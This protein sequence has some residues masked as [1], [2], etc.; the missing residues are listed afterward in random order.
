M[1]AIT[2]E[3]D[4]NPAGT[5]AKPPDELN[6]CAVEN[7]N[8]NGTD[9]KAVS[10]KVKLYESLVEEYWSSVVLSESKRTKQAPPRRKRSSL[11]KD[12][13]TKLKKRISSASLDE[14]ELRLDKL[15]QKRS[16]T[17]LPD[18]SEANPPIVVK[19]P[20]KR[21]KDI[22]STPNGAKIKPPRK[23]IS[24]S[25]IHAES[26]QSDENSLKVEANVALTNR[27]ETSTTQSEVKTRRH[28]IIHKSGMCEGVRRPRHASFSEP[29]TS[30]IMN[31]EQ[32]SHPIEPVRASVVILNQPKAAPRKRSVLEKAHSIAAL[33][34]TEHLRRSSLNVRQKLEKNRRKFTF[35][36]KI[37]SAFKSSSDCWPLAR[38]RKRVTR[39]SS[40]PPLKERL[41]ASVSTE[42]FS[43]IFINCDKKMSSGLPEEWTSEPA[44]DAIF[45]T[46]GREN[47][48]FP[49]Y[50]HATPRKQ[51]AVRT[52]RDK[53]LRPKILMSMNS[54][55]SLDS[56]ALRKAQKFLI[57]NL[58]PS[59]TR[60]RFK[61]STN[62]SPRD[63]QTQNS[64]DS[65]KNS[66]DTLDSIT[67]Q[68]EDNT[69]V[70]LTKIERAV[71]HDQANHP[72]PSG[73]KLSLKTKFFLRASSIPDMA[74]RIRK[75]FSKP[76]LATTSEFD[77]TGSESVTQ[78]AEPASLIENVPSPEQM[79]IERKQTQNSADNNTNEKINCSQQPIP[80]IIVHDSNLDQKYQNI[81]LSAGRPTQCNIGIN[82]NEL[83]SVLPSTLTEPT[84]TEAKD[85]SKTEELNET[86][87]AEI[88]PP[89]VSDCS[90]RDNVAKNT[91]SCASQDIVSTSNSCDV[92]TPFHDSSENDKVLGKS[93]SSEITNN[94]LDSSPLT[95]FSVCV[96]NVT[97]FE[98]H[99]EKSV[100]DSPSLDNDSVKQYAITISSA[101]SEKASVG[102]TKANEDTERVLKSERCVDTGMVVLSYEAPIDGEHVTVN[103]LELSP[104][105]MSPGATDADI[106]FFR[107]ISNCSDLSVTSSASGLAEVLTGL[108]AVPCSDCE[109]PICSLPI[110][111]VNSESQFKDYVIPEQLHKEIAR[112]WSLNQ[113]R[114]ECY[115]RTL[116]RSN[117][118]LRAS[119]RRRIRANSIAE[120]EDE[121]DSE[122][123]DTDTKDSCS[124]HVS[125]HVTK[126]T[127]PKP[128]KHSDNILYVDDK[129]DFFD[130]FRDRAHEEHYA[131]IIES[132][133]DNE[134]ECAIAAVE[135]LLNARRSS[136]DT[137]LS[138]NS[139]ES[140]NSA[141]KN[142]SCCAETGSLAMSDSHS[143]RGSMLPDIPVEKIENDIFDYFGGN[144]E[145]YPSET[146]ALHSASTSTPKNSSDLIKESEKLI[147]STIDNNVDVHDE[148]VENNAEMEVSNFIAPAKPPRTYSSDYQSSLSE[149]N[150]SQCEVEVTLTPPPE[151]DEIEDSSSD[152]NVDTTTD[153][154][155]DES[156]CNGSIEEIVNKVKEDYLPTFPVLPCDGRRKSNLEVE[157]D[158]IFET[159]SE[160][161]PDHFEKTSDINNA[162]QCLEK[163][164]LS[165]EKEDAAA[166]ATDSSKTEH[167]HLKD[168]ASKNPPMHE[169]KL[170]SKTGESFGQMNTQNKRRKS[171]MDV[172][173]SDDILGTFHDSTSTLGFEALNIQPPS[174]IL[175]TC[176]VTQLN[177]KNEKALENNRPKESIP[178]YPTKSASTLTSSAI[179]EIRDKIIQSAMNAT[180]LIEKL[181]G[182][183]SSHMNIERR[184]S[185]SADRTLFTGSISPSTNANEDESS[186]TLSKSSSDRFDSD[187]NETNLVCD[188]PHITVN[189]DEVDYEDDD[190]FEYFGD[191]APDENC[192]S[193]GDCDGDSSSICDNIDTF[194]PVSQNTSH[195]NLFDGEEDA[196]FS[197]SE[198]DE[199][200]MPDV[201]QEDTLLDINDI[202]DVCKSPKS[203]NASCKLRSEYPSSV[204]S[205]TADDIDINTDNQDEIIAERCS[206]DSSNTTDIFISSTKSTLRES[207]SEND[208]IEKETILPQAGSVRKTN[209]AI[210]HPP[211]ETIQSSLLPPPALK[212]NHNHKRLSV[213]FEPTSLHTTPCSHMMV[214]SSSKEDPFEAFSEHITIE[215]EE[216]TGIRVNTNTHEHSIIS[217]ISSDPL[218]KDKI[219]APIPAA[220]KLQRTGVPF[221][222][223][224]RDSDKKIFIPDCEICAKKIRPSLPNME[225]SP[226]EG[227]SELA[228]PDHEELS[229]SKENIKS[230]IP[231]NVKPPVSLK[232]VEYIPPKK[233]L[234]NATSNRLIL[235]HPKPVAK[236]RFTVN[237]VAFYSSIMSSSKAAKKPPLQRSSSSS[238]VF[239]AP[240]ILRII[241]KRNSD[242][243]LFSSKKR[244]DNSTKFGTSQNY[245][246]RITRSVSDEPRGLHS[247]T[248]HI[249]ITFRQNSHSLFS[250]LSK[251]SAIPE[252][253]LENATTDSKEPVNDCKTDSEL[254]ERNQSESPQ[255]LKCGDD[256]CHTNQQ[257]SNKLD[258]DDGSQI[259]VFNKVSNIL[260]QILSSSC[261]AL[262]D[263]DENK[264]DGL[265]L[266]LNPNLPAY[267]HARKALFPNV[268]TSDLVN[269]ERY[270]ENFTPRSLALGK[271][272]IVLQTWRE[273]QNEPDSIFRSS[274]S[275]SDLTEIFRNKILTPCST[276]NVARSASFSPSRKKGKKIFFLCFG[277]SYMI[278][279][280][281]ISSS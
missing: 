130:F 40:M 93:L 240:K 243:A 47:L 247:S 59:A 25:P 15:H 228:S 98:D 273:R 156:N 230:Q 119:D 208:M 75:A 49:E 30:C 266:P 252:T 171:F 113:G 218:N 10:E 36:R 253:V 195:I 17:S 65:D 202:G 101:K 147:K 192:S 194:R 193:C 97:S 50:V 205:Q 136:V 133:S 82:D 159:F 241:K 229:K 206:I 227:T 88:L 39:F 110:V 13:S 108:D 165:N 89:A 145:F 137:I 48:E 23:R 257:A 196:I 123:S 242:S 14:S 92:M 83:V 225:V 237:K 45:A 161:I 265:F 84:F 122:T 197:Y 11:P 191:N 211:G 55:S 4:S 56:L 209:T 139:D 87:T 43:S 63:I 189:G 21:S 258:I 255:P 268:S 178:S 277:V 185:S 153:K 152:E 46:D 81:S 235:P 223:L 72:A 177:N 275:T 176:Y 9:S 120:C 238:T 58:S 125:K 249:P 232:T 79:D 99:E 276:P 124:L 200:G 96:N 219:N 184:D 64:L 271:P 44:C 106:P 280:F 78:I 18:I 102:S 150:P 162:P 135:Y 260:P 143:R 250:S 132:D 199:I 216:S 278:H 111:E 179:N 35:S 69:P 264:V 61:F 190:F 167:L 248:H 256:V 239:S 60:S 127:S 146:S 204:S 3:L 181:N 76:A 26:Q 221:A 274:H 183:S 207:C 38:K 272:T 157:S 62:E 86:K 140:S 226:S 104:E 103:L 116:N 128:S 33:N 52:L 234:P 173:D 105:A 151:K 262:L 186:V 170:S 231:E 19:P 251:K 8:E 109:S 7:D 20:R 261:D 160:N 131:H 27:D 32:L 51:S 6:S 164:F 154:L 66:C 114:R 236:H 73:P 182:K 80:D 188:N 158:D 1:S 269:L 31:E 203:P 121:N 70:P 215:R 169:K 198:S 220:I 85:N 57:S 37:R 107:E 270:D 246:R 144:D 100:V 74:P 168:D 263:S 24:L 163:S 233:I 22:T 259:Q 166:S 138:H 77:S 91:V 213:S 224:R 210:L 245:D 212:T 134:H 214:S 5:G 53:L 95:G 279:I 42:S 267:C 129:D 28:G 41:E 172:D 174:V 94:K 244:G 16:L 149:G 54:A 117:N 90:N 141:N 68:V 29:V 175:E 180:D 217:D 112:E 155:K 34:E 126:S 118:L 142:K 12:G 71:S 148:M 201:V 222:L 254:V 67:P 2:D 187:S 115:S 281:F